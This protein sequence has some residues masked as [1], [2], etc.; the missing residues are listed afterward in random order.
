MLYDPITRVYPPKGVM[1]VVIGGLELQKH[2]V[3][4]PDGTDEEENL[5]RRVVERDKIGEKIEI[6]GE[7][8]QGEEAL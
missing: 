7:K 1:V 6:A 2:Q 5:H 4:S 3:D 8:H